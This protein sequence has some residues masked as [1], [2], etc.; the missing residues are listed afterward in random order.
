MLSQR[1][2]G[3]G[4]RDVKKEVEERGHVKPFFI[5]QH[6]NAFLRHTMYN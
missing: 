6:N 5:I 4:G 3:E 2:C 1:R